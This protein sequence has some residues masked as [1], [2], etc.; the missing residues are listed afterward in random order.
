[1]FDLE[2]INMRP[3]SGKLQ[4]KSAGAAAEQTGRKM[5]AGDGFECNRISRKPIKTTPKSCIDFYNNAKRRGDKIACL[6]CAKVQIFLKREDEIMGR[7]AKKGTQDPIVVE[8]REIHTKPVVVNETPVRDTQDPFSG[9]KQYHPNDR[10]TKNQP[11]F[12]T[13]TGH[14]LQF[15][16]GATTEHNLMQFKSIDLLYR[17]GRIGCV[18]HADESG[19]LKLRVTDGNRVTCSSHGFCRAF[20]VPGKFFS[21]RGNIIAHSQDRIEIVLSEAAA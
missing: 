20:N 14:H 16:M 15:S 2:E 1:M 13:I 21:K 17:D 8:T 3:S 18:M 12:A 4:T 6:E 9:W 10:Y 19:S 7:P 5:Q 11:V